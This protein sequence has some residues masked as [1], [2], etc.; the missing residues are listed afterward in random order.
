LPIKF[1]RQ[2][3]STTS[4]SLCLC[5]SNINY[6]SGSHCDIQMNLTDSDWFFHT[7]SLLR[8]P[9][10][11]ERPILIGPYKKL[12]GSL[13]LRLSGVRKWPLHPLVSY[14]YFTLSLSILRISQAWLLVL[15]AIAHS[16]D[17]NLKI[18]WSSERVS[19]CGVSWMK[20]FSK[21]RECMEE[22][23][24]CIAFTFCSVVFERV[25]C[26]GV[27]WM[28]TFSKSRECMEEKNMCIAF[29][30]CSVVYRWLRTTPNRGLTYSLSPYIA[31]KQTV[32]KIRY[33]YT[34]WWYTMK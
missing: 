24:M 30:F 3:S 15:L 2:L 23:D 9:L 31:C 6:I 32:I 29:T 7:A 4:L 12:C 34:T 19:C 22:K 27:S 1:D 11:W 25:S 28:K 8:F 10:L 18:F 13:G 17:L 21:S 5:L 14:E 26:C 16:G 20:T 33:G